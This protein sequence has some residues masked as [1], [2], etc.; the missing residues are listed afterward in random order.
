MAPEDE[1]IPLLL[2]F[3][4]YLSEEYVASFNY[5]QNVKPLTGKLR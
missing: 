4:Y 5:I 3:Y 1:E 2:A